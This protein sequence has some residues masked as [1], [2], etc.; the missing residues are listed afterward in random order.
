MTDTVAARA[1]TLATEITEENIIVMVER[2]Y[3]SVRVHPT[4]AAV[5]NPRLEGRWDPHLNQMK[6]FWSSVLLQSGIY[7]GHPLG[8]HF[9]VPGMQ[10]EHFADWLDL[11]RQTLDGI[12]AEQQA[13]F[14]HA[15][16]QRIAARFSYALFTLVPQENG[17]QDTR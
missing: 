12:Y 13:D 5:F 2:F 3:D 6:R 4:L 10:H 8:A 9:G 14:I 1:G 15:T 17:N 7:Q 16:A 11:F